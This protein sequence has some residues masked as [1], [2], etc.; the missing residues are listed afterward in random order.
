MTV[1]SGGKV[2]WGN[3]GTPP[4]PTD[5]YF[6]QQILFEPY[7]TSYWQSLTT[8]DMA[9]GKVHFNNT[10][11]K[12]GN[13]ISL[14]E[15]YDSASSLY[16]RLCGFYQNP[17][18]VDN[19][20]VKIKARWFSKGENIDIAFVNA[21]TDFNCNPLFVGNSRCFVT[22]LS[23]VIPDGIYTVDKVLL[24]RCARTDVNSDSPIVTHGKIRYKIV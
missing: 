16:F 15:N 6:E 19:N 21:G 23:I 17:G 11:Q 22:N 4:A 3:S 5:Q 9:L 2:C 20:V 14:H 18:S 12:G 7:I 8:A 24:I 10:T 1:R 13:M